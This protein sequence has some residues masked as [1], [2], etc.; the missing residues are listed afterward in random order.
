MSLDF[1]VLGQNGSPER[2]V[3]LGVDLHHQLLTAAAAGGLTRFQDFADYYRDAEVS[4]DDLPDLVEQIRA[5][6]DKTG[7]AEL[8]RFLDDLGGLITYAVN[9]RRALHAIAD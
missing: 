2:T 8:Q 9:Q 7:S 3:S 4:I 5:L 6:H 1:A